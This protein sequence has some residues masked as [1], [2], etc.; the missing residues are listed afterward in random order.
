MKRHLFSLIIIL[1]ALLMNGCGDP[2]PKP[3][4]A[5]IVINEVYSRG[6]IGNEYGEYD[7]VEF[8]NA[9]DLEGDL[10]NF[11]IYDDG[12]G[13]ND[14]VVILPKG[15]KIAPKS[16]LIVEVAKATDAYNGFGLSSMGD[17]V[18]LVDTSNVMIDSVKFG[19]LD[20]NQAYARRPDGS[21]TFAIQMP[22]RGKSNNFGVA[23]AYIK[24]Y[25]DVPKDEDEVIIIAAI[26]GGGGHLLWKIN[27]IEQ[28]QI[29]LRSNSGEIYP[30]TFEATIPVQTAGTV[31]EYTVVAEDGSTMVKLS[32]S[33]T[34]LSS[35]FVDYSKLKINEVNGVAKWFEIYNTGS[36]DINLAGVEAY[37]SNKEPAI[38]NLTWTGDITQIIPAHGYFSTE[39]I[40]LGTGLSANN[41]NVRLQLRT[42]NGNEI[43]TYTK[44]IDINS[45]YSAI[46]NKSHARVP[47]GT[48]EWYYT[49]DGIGTSGATNG[50]STTGYVKFG[51][52]QSAAD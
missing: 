39:G 3:Q 37:Y 30:P 35:V 17:E 38:Y 22:T 15:T 46:K 48:G 34:V 28:P 24:Q 43:D 7:W 1:S 27:G 19:A 23:I 6:E 10:S 9:G 45:G 49:T 20:P 44:L 32:G 31:V 51:N 13:V 25:P 40:T 41:A 5:K 47:D 4:P 50:T 52:E 2:P 14:K 42:P 33:Y 12:K 26:I 11:K 16:F 29:E 8:Y 21:A 18:I 36:T